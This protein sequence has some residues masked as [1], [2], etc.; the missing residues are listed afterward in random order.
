[1]DIDSVGTVLCSTDL[2]S[3][4]SAGNVAGGGWFY[5]NRDTIGAVSGSSMG[6][7]TA[8]GDQTVRLVPGPG[9]A[10]SGIY[11]CSLPDTSSQLQ[12]VYVGMYRA[13]EGLFR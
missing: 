1:M 13:S 9:I 4:C 7:Y 8:Y 3:C 12:T 6:F 2:A 10:V 5:P 11:T